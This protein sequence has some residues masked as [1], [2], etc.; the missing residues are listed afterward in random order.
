LSIVLLTI[1]AVMGAA[2]LV[3]LV[4]AG[5]R[6]QPRRPRRRGGASDDGWR[7]ARTPAGADRD[8][9]WRRDTPRRLA[10]R[11]AVLRRRRILLAL[12]IA[13]VMAVRAWYLLGGRWWIAEVVTGS[14][15]LAYL[16]ALVV[17]GRR[18]HRP[19]RVAAGA[20][21]AHRQ[22]WPLR[23]RRRAEL[24]LWSIPLLEGQAPSRTE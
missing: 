1:A 20:R 3:P 11:G 9:P 13:V 19:A 8:G 6:G 21:P 16:G 22:R 7:P 12:A 14:L 4:V 23:K 10:R 24:P 2:F 5:G 18:W 17:P 15:L